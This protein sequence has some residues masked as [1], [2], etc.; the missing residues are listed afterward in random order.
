MSK[1]ILPLLVMK[2]VLIYLAAHQLLHQ[3]IIF[4]FFIIFCCCRPQT[5]LFQGPLTPLMEFLS[6]AQFRFHSDQASVT[7]SHIPYLDNPSLESQTPTLCSVF[8]NQCLKGRRGDIFFSVEQVVLSCKGKER[9]RNET[10]IIIN[11][12]SRGG[13]NILFR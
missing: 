8:Q 6:L 2:L 4:F 3:S 7:P 1:I 13:A 10:A 9:Q 5:P 11:S 12:W